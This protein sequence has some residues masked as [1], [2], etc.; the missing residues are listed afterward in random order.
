MLEGRPEL[1]TMVRAALASGVSIILPSH[2]GFCQS[3]PGS[4]CPSL[5]PEWYEVTGLSTAPLWLKKK[6]C[7]IRKGRLFPETDKFW[8][9]H[10]CLGRDGPLYLPWVGKDGHVGGTVPST[11]LAHRR[12][13]VNTL[14]WMLKAMAPKPES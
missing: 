14:N 6:W 8:L 3:Y 7:L 2:P 1:L 11:S 4:S 9:L 12:H 5:E 13:L 10:A